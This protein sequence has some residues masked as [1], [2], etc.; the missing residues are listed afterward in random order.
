MAGLESYRS[1]I[2]KLFFSLVGWRRFVQGFHDLYILP[3]T[4]LTPDPVL[5]RLKV[6]ILHHLVTIRAAGGKRI[7]SYL[8]ALR[9]EDLIEN[10]FY[11][12][13]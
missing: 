1:Y 11:K 3:L 2:V 12:I 7:D 8:P 13:P 9:H 6:V 10:P 5:P 4:M